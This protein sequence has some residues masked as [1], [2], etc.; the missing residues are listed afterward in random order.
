MIPRHPSPNGS[1]STNRGAHK[2][3]GGIGMLSPFPFASHSRAA[4]LENLVLRP[5]VARGDHRSD[6]EQIV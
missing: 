3:G 6:N 1:P 2:H 4:Y 5:T